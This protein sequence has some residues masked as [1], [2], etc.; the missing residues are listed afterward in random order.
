[1]QDKH[2]IADALRET[3]HLLK[4]KGA[5]KFKVKAYMSAAKVLDAT[6]ED[7]GQLVE[8]QSLTE[9]PG[10]GPALSGFIT[11]LYENDETTL[12]NNLRQELP[13][14]TAEL[15]QV[16]GM[17]LK[18]IETISQKL[19]ITSVRELEDACKQGA[20]SDLKGFGEKVQTELLRAI[21]NLSNATEEMRLLKA[22]AISHELLEF[23]SS[24]LP[25]LNLNLQ[26]A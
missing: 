2:Q 16:D 20:L 13:K 5:N 11:E 12:L 25:N 15:S 17:T 4:A 21:Q 24:N 10:I 14:G 23:L 22:R 19:N 26:G 6:Q 7:L 8:N 1:M 3:G 18:R 9:L